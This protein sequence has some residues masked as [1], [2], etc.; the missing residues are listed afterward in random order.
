[1]TSAVPPAL[2]RLQIVRW[3]NAIFVVF[4]LCGMGFA[5]WA[6]RVPLVAESLRLDTSQVGVLLFGLAIGSI[7]GL[8]ASG[9]L[10]AVFGARKVMLVTLL[11]APVGLVVASLGATVFDSF[12]LAF[13]ALAV[14]GAGIGTCDVAMNVSGA[15]NERALGRSIMPIYHAF[16]SIGT[17]V[18]AGLGA[19][20]ELLSVPLAIHIGVIGAVMVISILAVI[21]FAQPEDHDEP[22]AAD[23][24][25]RE[26]STWRTRLSIWRDPRTL[27]I[28]LIVLGMAF[29]E[30]SANDWLSYAMVYGHGTG[31]STGALVFG[32]FVTAMTIGRLSGVKLLDR[33]GRVPVLRW[34]A[35]LAVIGLLLLIFSPIVWIAIVGVVLWGLGASLG[36]PVG[37]SAAADDPRTA[38]A[39]VSAVATIGYLAFLVGPPAIGALGDA[40]G[41]LNGLL[42]VLILV[43]VAGVASSAAREPAKPAPSTD[44][45]SAETT[46]T[47]STPA[48]TTRS[49]ASGDH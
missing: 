40:V 30:G 4:A 35:V 34:S 27:F 10:V 9:H 49:T 7:V 42:I 41:I 25:P 8:V 33:F 44:A 36:F 46:S 37:M 5:S 19:V 21:R 18:G 1:M 11:V 31:A 13:V 3:R 15:A 45:G 16:F 26:A 23:D 24:T 29:A 43:V 17:I 38:A 22:Q 20:A 47:S 39:R 12:A 2:T 6:A 32:V 28:G 48:A 14:Y